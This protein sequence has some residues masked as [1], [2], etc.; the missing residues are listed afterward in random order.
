MKFTHKHLD[1]LY[2]AYAASILEIDN[3]TAVLVASEE[4]GY[5]IGRAS[6]RERV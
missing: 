1:E 4:K 3:E 2:R 5:Q 6:C